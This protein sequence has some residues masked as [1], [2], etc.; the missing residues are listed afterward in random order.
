MLHRQRDCSLS[1]AQVRY[2]AAVL[3]KECPSHI[4]ADL[5]S[6]AASAPA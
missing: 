6:L 4:T 3:S 2:D 1:P 5:L